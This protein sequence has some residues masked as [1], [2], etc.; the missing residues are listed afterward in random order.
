M[1]RLGA[2]PGAMPGK[3]IER[4]RERMPDVPLELVP[5]A[6]A[7]Q[8]A[9]L[10]GG[11]IDA[12]IVRLPLPGDPDAVH[13]IRLYDEVPVVVAGADSSLLAVD[14]LR[15]EDLAGEVRVTPADD[16][17][18][19]LDL[20]TEAPRFD[21]P[22]TTEDAIAVVAAGVGIAVMPMSLA[23]LHHR[24]DVEYRPLVDAPR[25]T[26]ALAWRRDRDTDDVQTF[27]GITRGRTARSSR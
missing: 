27:V 1:F 25:S 19:P 11:E 3:W 7:D 18:G 22:A 9:A 20:P 21:A 16:V 10:D 17:I 24:R 8:R 13:V 5:I 4:W 15:A 23:R 26:V 6:V 14:E 2:I 12:A